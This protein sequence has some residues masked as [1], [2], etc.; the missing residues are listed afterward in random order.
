[1]RLFCVVPGAPADIKAVVSSPQSLKVSWLPPLDP[2]G[3]ITKYNLYR[4]NMDGRQEVDNA[5]Q[6]ISSQHTIFEVKGIQ[7]HIEY[8][9]WV[10]ASTRIGEGQSSKVVSQ[11]ATPR[12]KCWKQYSCAVMIDNY[13]ITVPARIISFGGV[14]VRPW[15]SSVAFNCESVGSPRREWLRNDQILKVS[16]PKIDNDNVY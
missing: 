14:M 15:R 8:Q 2:N 9:F 11:V 16:L 12:G 4:R 13:V 3:V 7:S 5:K 1:M 10:T 6:T